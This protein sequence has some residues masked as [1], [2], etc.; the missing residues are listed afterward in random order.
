VLANFYKSKNNAEILSEALGRNQ[1]PMPDTPEIA[2]PLVEHMVAICID[3]ESS[4]NNTDLMTE[5]GLNTIFRQK[6]RETI[7]SPGPG[8]HGE[9]LMKALDFYHFRVVEHAH[10][11]SNREGSLGPLG[12]RFGHTRFATF[13]ELR[14]ILKHFFNQDI[15]SDNPALRGCKRPVVLVGHALK[16]DEDNVKK[17]GEKYDFTK[18]STMV[19]KVDTQPL[20]R[21][22]ETWI[23]H[24]TMPTNEVGLRVL[25][26]EKLGF[27]HLDNHTA[28]NDAARTMMS[29][30]KMIL[31][32]KF[33]KNQPYDM[34]QVAVNVEKHSGL[35]SHLL[36]P[37]GTVECCIRCGGRDHSIDV[38]TATV[39]CAA[40]ERFDLNPDQVT[41]DEMVAS[42]IE[43]YCP[44]VARFKAWARRYKDAAKKYEATRKAFSDEVLRGPGP[45]AHPFSTWTKPDKPVW[46]LNH[47]YE[48]LEGMT[49]S[50]EPAAIVYDLPSALGGLPV[51]PDDGW[52]VIAPRSSSTATTGPTS[53]PVAPKR[54]GTAVSEP[55]STSLASALSSL[56]ISDLSALPTGSNG[57]TEAVSTS[58][59][60]AASDSAYLSE[61]AS[62]FAPVA[63]KV[64]T[65]SEQRELSRRK[66]EERGGEGRGAIGASGGAKAASAKTSWG[67]D[68]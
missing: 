19:A 34:Q 39:V 11:L 61:A 43:T 32:L 2:K 12:N 10:L 53:T 30:I 66:H 22:T 8:P 16:H 55:G 13:K 25:V 58:N 44:H 1:S 50:K 15:M 18:Y 62:V 27:Y 36:T 5:L 56:L 46:P 67:F 41:Q 21:E 6:A 24:P 63:R 26:E 60:S 57:N 14:V 40:C 51:P 33:T 23:P 38:C 20:A 59:A 3:T 64:T 9:N 17:M 68:D 45:G 48:V 31:P 54:N 7:V 47:W 4:T 49:M 35:D 29:A 28:S 37:Y 65:M 52:N 42:H